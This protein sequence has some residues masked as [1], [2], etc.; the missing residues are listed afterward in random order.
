MY[1]Q[2]NS[3]ISYKLARVHQ[4]VK[5]RYGRVKMDGLFIFHAI[6]REILPVI[7]FIC[8]ISCRIMDFA[9]Y[10]MAYRRRFHAQDFVTLELV[11]SIH[12]AF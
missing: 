6:E 9:L 1:H 11:T 3:T 4:K 2:T 5:F 12:I 10:L 8:R 7:A